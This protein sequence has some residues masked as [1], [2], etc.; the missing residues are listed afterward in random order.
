MPSSQTKPNQHFGHNFISKFTKFTTNRRNLVALFRLAEKHLIAYSFRCSDYN[1][2]YFKKYKL[3]NWNQFDLQVHK[4]AVRL[5]TAGLPIIVSSKCYAIAEF[6]NKRQVSEETPPPNLIC[7][8]VSWTK[9]IELWDLCLLNVPCSN[10]NLIVN[11]HKQVIEFWCWNQFI[12]LAHQNKLC[13]DTY[14]VI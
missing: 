4:F 14:N 11:I 3:S 5:F 12:K 8:C 2:N 13:P 7:V 1:K 10:G 6:N 9:V